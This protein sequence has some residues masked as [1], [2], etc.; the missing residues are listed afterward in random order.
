MF[1][2]ISVTKQKSIHG[3]TTRRAKSQYPGAY[4][5]LPTLNTSPDDFPSAVLLKPRI[6]QSSDRGNCEIRLSL[7]HTRPSR[8]SSVNF[9]PLSQFG[10][11][12]CKFHIRWLHNEKPS[13]L[14]SSPN[15]IQAIKTRPGYAGHVARMGEK[16]TRGF[17]EE[18]RGT[19]HLEDLAVDGGKY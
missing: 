17:G 19:A 8:A 13:N 18:T 3:T 4:V 14:Y 5:H 11:G 12:R 15:I 2:R 7:Q 16:C 10:Y 6:N 1:N 9:G